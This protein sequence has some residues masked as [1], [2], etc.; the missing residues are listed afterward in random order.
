MKSTFSLILMML[1]FTIPVLAQPFTENDQAFRLRLATVPS[2]GGTV[3]EI[4]DTFTAADGTDLTNHVTS[5]GS[6]AWLTDSPAIS[7]YNNQATNNVT[8]GGHY[9]RYWINHTMSSANYTATIT[10]T[11]WAFVSGRI[12]CLA[13]RDTGA[14]TGTES[15]YF[16]YYYYGADTI[17][18]WKIVNG[19]PTQ[20]GTDLATDANPKTLVLSASGS[21]I[22]ATVNGTNIPG[23]PIVDADVSGPGY[24]GMGQ[25]Y[26]DNN[27]GNQISVDNL[28][29]TVP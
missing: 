18:L 13:I 23:T 5:T 25:A 3:T 21:T 29:V 15:A 1:A 17:G 6:Y 16:I 28:T 10:V 22:T 27:L 2:G 26:R 14:S 24:V 7:I 20:L 9:A 8:P 19:T 12:F 11:P 4:A